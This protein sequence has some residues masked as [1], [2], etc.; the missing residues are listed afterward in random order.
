MFYGAI[1]FVCIGKLPLSAVRLESLLGLPSHALQQPGVIEP[2]RKRGYREIWLAGASMGGI[3][4]VG[5]D[6]EVGGR[7]VGGQPPQLHQMIKVDGRQG[8][9][10]PRP[11]PFR[12]QCQKRRGVGNVH[13]QHSCAKAELHGRHLRSGIVCAYH[14]RPPLFEM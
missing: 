1:C 12:H 13:G 6:L 8:K 14:G 9:A 4:A 10:L 3:G 7:A 11:Q 2:L 5:R